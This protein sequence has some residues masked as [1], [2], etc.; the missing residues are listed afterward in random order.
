ME[1]IVEVKSLKKNETLTPTEDTENTDENADFKS[2]ACEV[3]DFSVA[4]V[5]K[6]KNSC[7]TN[8]ANAGFFANYTE[9]GEAF[10]LPVAH[11]VCDFEAENKWTEHYCEERGTFNG[12]KFSFDSSKWSYQN[13]N[14]NKAVSSLIIS[15]G[16]ASIQEIVSLPDNC[17]YVISG[18]PVIRNGEDVSYNNLVLA[19]GWNSSNL[20]TTY[21]TFIGLKEN[22]DKIYIIGWESKTSNL[23]STSEAYKLF[24]QYGFKDLIKLDGGGSFYLNI[25]GEIT[26]TSE[27]RRIN[28]IV[29]FVPF[30]NNTT[31]DSNKDE[32]NSS[33]NNSSNDTTSNG[34]DKE[35]LRWVE[36]M[37]RYR[38][39]LASRSAT[40]SQHVKEAVQL[41]LTDGSRPCDLASR[42]EVMTMVKNAVNLTK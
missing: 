27:N 10:T 36:Y 28:S 3:K 14:Y 12:D 34:T 2:V 1:G 15:D 41:G 23:V 26:K 4:M 11:L 6:A 7:G 9:D 39:E 19:Q 35:Y 21:H 24:S 18:I 29:R 20:R 17:E 22:D 30:K 33:D 31:T 42:E 5:D 32:N 13:E 25:D 40:L 16:K 38:T 37:E 8:C